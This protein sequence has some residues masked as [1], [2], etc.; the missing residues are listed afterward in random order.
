MS[1]DKRT[2]EAN[3]HLYQGLRLQ[4][5]QAK[6]NKLPDELASDSEM[7]EL[8][9]DNPLPISQELI[10]RLIKLLKES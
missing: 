2:F 5:R 3:V 6:G 10:L 1:E 8:S 7:G 9:N 4:A